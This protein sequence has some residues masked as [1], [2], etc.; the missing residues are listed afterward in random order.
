MSEVFRIVVIDDPVTWG[1]R[2]L[3]VHK[4]AYQVAANRG[5]PL[6]IELRMIA[7]S[8]AVIDAP[9]AAKCVS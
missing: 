4:Y 1:Q 6:G 3:D 5:Q 9:N 7:H 2:L 8:G